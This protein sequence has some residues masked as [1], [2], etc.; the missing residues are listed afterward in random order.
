MQNL[1]SYIELKINQLNELLL[2]YGEQHKKEISKDENNQDNELIALIEGKIQAYYS[3]VKS[4]RA[5][6]KHLELS[7]N[8]DNDNDNNSKG[9]S[10]SN[11][12]T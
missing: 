3:I 6:Q 1:N 12:I 8:N 4:F 11:I 2:Q 9:N 7:D 5:D 10:G